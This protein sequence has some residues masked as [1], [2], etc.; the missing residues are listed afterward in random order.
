MLIG[1]DD[2]L[3]LGRRRAE[4][5]RGGAGH[6]LFLAGEAG[7]GKTRLLGS[8]A[9]DAERE[10]M[11]VI[12]AA[13]FSGDLDLPGALLIDLG[14]G[15][16]AS[17]VETERV[18]GEAILQRLTAEEA[19]TGDSHRRRRLLVLEVVDRIAGLVAGGPL[20]LALEDLHWADDLTLEAMG[21]LGRRLDSL[22]MLVVGTYRSDELYPRVP[23]R[24]WRARLITG[25]LAEEARLARLTR[26]QT[27]TMARFLLGEDPV[28]APAQLV[29]A[30]QARSDGIPLHVE[31]LM[32]A[33]RVSG[34][35]DAAAMRVPDTLTDAILQRRA[36]LS[37]DTSRVVD[38]AA[39]IDRSFDLELLAA[40]ADR[41]L[42]K[43]AGAI[44]EMESRYFIVPAVASGWF[45]F[46]HAL[47]RDALEGAVS[48]AQRRALHER[49]ARHIASRPGLADDGFLSAHFEA[50]GLN[51]EAYA[52]A[53]SAATHAASVSA[54]REALELYRRAIRC[55]PA[56]LTADAH[57][58]L[59]AARAIEEAAT[60]DNEAAATTYSEAHRLLLADGQRGRAAALLPPL[61]AARHL[62]GD[63]LD[64]RVAILS[65][66]LGELD[67]EDVAVRARLTAGV[68]AAYMLDRRLDEAVTHGDRAIEL[69]AEAG[70]ETTEL[71]AL[72]TLGAVLVFTGRMDAGWARLGESVTRARAASVEAE[73]ARTYRMM[74]SSASVLV[75]YDRAEESLRT[76]IEYA[77]RTEQWNH[78]HYMAAHLGHVLWATGAWDDAAATTQHALA[79]GR[80]GI[81]TRIT[82]LHVL[83]YLALGRAKWE[84]AEAI[85][86]EARAL[87]EE[88]GEL[89]R[90][91]P[92]LWGLAEASLL[93]GRYAD[94]AR[95]TDAGHRASAE[96]RDAAYLFPFL[97]TGTRAR[98]A[99]G[100]LGKAERW[101][102]EVSAALSDRSIPGT[103]PAID[104]A[105][106][107]LAL[108]RGATGRARTALRA[109]RDGWQVRR[110]A[111]EGCAATIDLARCAMR[112]NRPG[113]AASLVA[114]AT[115]AAQVMGA[116]ALLAVAR[117]AETVLRQRGVKQERWAP[118]TAREFEV[119][120]LIAAGRTNREIAAE[121][122]ITPKTVASHVEHILARLGADRRTEIATWVASVHGRA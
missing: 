97:V 95:L 59:L 20:V 53:L 106:G 115:A 3:A 76:G 4:S 7:I 10:G 22:P 23:M 30:L 70:D 74:G 105:A 94:A 40:V 14:H 98:L 89:Q 63:T 116:D 114:E 2:L 46:R 66:G 77:E 33:V 72:T 83:G 112:A 54:H 75:E 48:L 36:A 93:Q 108:A 35:T 39:I 37:R 28:P 42:D 96:V 38:A 67:A 57:A 44:A 71:N 6:L 109:A 17:R 9:R 80:G 29:D 13:A 1:R 91:S 99:L 82:A 101:V 56:D 84:L 18:T 120:S 27:G 31:E 43:V 41:P 32:G 69:A 60:D 85:L 90:Y 65:T 47:I 25:R 21:Q 49:V 117:D 11:R 122:T 121:L 110:R 113:E 104:H 81:T 87:G 102:D 103:M 62:L 34:S 64:S 8:M 88:M 12:R 118:L 73:A 58:T 15:L 45:D 68:S 100:D 26:E 5:A 119:A 51:Q 61:V 16:A 86:G 107:L 55:A 50:A 111:W 19:A 92:A 78:R 52:R 79:D 24:E